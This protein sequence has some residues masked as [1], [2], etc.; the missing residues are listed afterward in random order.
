M[1]TSVYLATADLML[2]SAAMGA[3]DNVTL[4]DHAAAPTC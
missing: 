2:T 4:L 1:T 3:R